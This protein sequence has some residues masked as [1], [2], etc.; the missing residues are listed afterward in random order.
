MRR[1]EPPPP[2]PLLPKKGDPCRS[3]RNFNNRNGPIDPDIME[4]LL[5]GLARRT[6]EGLARRTREDL[7]R[8]TKG[9]TG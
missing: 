8:G 5:E 4:L 6:R 9:R 2:P 1:K 7:A 3:V